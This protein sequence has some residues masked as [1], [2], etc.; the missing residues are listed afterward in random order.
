MSKS[1]KKRS[2]GLTP[3]REYPTYQG[4]YELHPR[5]ELT[6]DELYAKVVLITIDWLRE[7]VRKKGGDPEFLDVYPLSDGYKDFDVSSMEDINTTEGYYVRVI[8]WGE[9]D[10]AITALV[11]EMENR[12][13]E[14]IVILA[15]YEEAMKGLLETNEGL[16]SRIPNW[17]DFPDY[18]TGEL[19]EIFKL[20]VTER[21]FKATKGAVDQARYIFEKAR[22]MDGFGNGRYVRNLVDRAVQNQS[23]RLMSGCE[24]AKDVNRRDLFTLKKEDITTIDEDRFKER[25]AGTA[26]KELDAM[27]GLA[28]VKNLIGKAIANYNMNKY[29]LEKGIAREK[30]SLH[31]VFTG[32]PGTAK[33]TVARLVGEMLRDEK[34]LPSGHFVEVGRADLVG[35]FSGHTPFKVKE[36]FRKARGGVLF[37][38]EAYALCDGYNG[39]YGDEAINTIV[40][41]MEN[42]R[43]DTIVIFAGY[44]GPMKQFLERNPGMRSRIAFQIEFEDYTVDELCDITRLMVSK[45]NMS[46]TDRAMDKLRKIYEKENQ[47]SDYGNGRF[48][49]KIL[50][51]AEMNIAQSLVG[52]NSS[53]LTKKQI[54]TID[55]DHIPDANTEKADKTTPKRRIGFVS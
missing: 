44:P 7:R 9:K 43:E 46:L 6:V 31:M 4:I 55:E 48:V 28:S 37:I 25:P 24:D 14:V 22:Y 40:Q 45:K 54:S 26:R 17:I 23:V 38:D 8:N 10:S 27:I 33:T 32:N 18:S 34:V 39:G 53:R 51:E 12:R 47:K 21:G 20:N 29:C 1:R 49:R 5:N 42:H 52:I 36:A 3:L 50:E 11:Q 35:Q 15:G 30:A 19:T 16:K 41:E 13:D 2:V